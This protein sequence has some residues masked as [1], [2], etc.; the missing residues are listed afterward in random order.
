MASFKKTYDTDSI[1]LR[2]IFAVNPDTNAR[3]SANTFLVTGPNGVGSFQDAFGF[4]STIS[5]PTSLVGGS[6][7]TI[8]NQNG[9][10]IIATSSIGVDDILSTVNGLGS[11]G[12]ISTAIAIINLSSIIST[13]QLTSSIEGLGSLGYLSTSQLT[14]S[15]KG[16]GSL[17]YLSTTQLASTIANLGNIYNSTILF[18]GT[19]ISFSSNANQITINGQAG[20]V[21][22]II[23]G[24]GITIDKATGDVTVTATGITPGTVTDV[25]LTSTIFGLANFGY[26]STLALMSSTKGLGSLGYLSSF[27][28]ISSINLSSGSIVASYLSSQKIMVSSITANKF[29]GDGSLLTNINTGNNTGSGSA[30]GVLF[31]LNFSVAD[32]YGG[33]NI[34]FPTKSLEFKTTSGQGTSQQTNLNATTGNQFICG[35]QSSTD[36]PGFIPYGIWD[37][38]IF[39]TTTGNDVNIYCKLY[40]YNSGTLS[41]IGISSSISLIPG[42]TVNQVTTTVE[43]AYTQLVTGDTIYVELYVNKTSAAANETITIHYEEPNA[44]SHVHTTF[45]GASATT[46]STLNISSGSLFTGTASTTEI[47][48][49]RLNFGT[50]Y[51]NGIQLI[52]TNGNFLFSFQTL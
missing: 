14:S 25:N 41:L 37:F 35:F 38:N 23:A 27:N 45:L 10:Y 21:T 6:G 3:I 29:I 44:Y 32:Q 47:N 16:L 33:A 24:S 19:N 48:A 30:N 39:L 20:G 22:S 1:V 50:L 51:N 18:P 34:Q 12:Y 8:T 42:T 7:V 46:M 4:L 40:V 2:R 11:A 9:N 36:I 5:V 17:G 13:P 31:Y 15:I 49:G 26:V 43:V 52:D 28:T